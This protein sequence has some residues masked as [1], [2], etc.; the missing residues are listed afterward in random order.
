MLAFCFV[1]EE[2]WIVK[3]AVFYA[4]SSLAI[5]IVVL[6]DGNY[7]ETYGMNDRYLGQS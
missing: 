2:V 1:E 7:L 6:V 4:I 5:R 3:R